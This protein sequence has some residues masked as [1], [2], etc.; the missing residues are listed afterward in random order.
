[1]NTMSVRNVICYAIMA[2]APAALVAQSVPQPD[3]ALYD[4]GVSDLRSGR[5]ERARLTLQTLIN[6]YQASGMLAP[7]KLAIADS[8]YREGGTNGFA[9]AEKECKELIAQFPDTPSSSEAQQLMRKIQDAR[10]AK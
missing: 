3:K 4:A 5:F 2:L 8:W 10:A 7:A 1:M 9:Q 6:T